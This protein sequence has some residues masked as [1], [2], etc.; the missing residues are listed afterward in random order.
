MILSFRSRV[1][2][3]FWERNDISRLPADRVARITMLLDRLDASAT[4]DDMNLPGFG[5]HQLRGRNSGRY[6]VSVSAN[7]RITFGWKGEDAIEIDFEDYH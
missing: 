4:P 5:F 3:R 2:K 6:A 1:L 7:W